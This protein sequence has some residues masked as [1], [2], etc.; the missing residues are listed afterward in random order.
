MLPH[1]TLINSNYHYTFAWRTRRKGRTILTPQSPQ[2][3]W[4]DSSSYVMVM[5]PNKSAISL[6]VL[7][8]LKFRFSPTI[9]AILLFLFDCFF[10]FSRNNS[11]NTI[12]WANV[13][14]RY[15]VSLW[16]NRTKFSSPSHD[17]TA[18]NIQS[19]PFRQDLLMKG[20]KTRLTCYVC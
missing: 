6:P 18:H 17:D 12:F 9:F 15:R 2:S 14:F 8:G 16:E 13:A 5:C 1:H 10:S 7:K 19:R 4:K 11:A 3:Q 20:S